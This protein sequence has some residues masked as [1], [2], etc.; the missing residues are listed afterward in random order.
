MGAAFQVFDLRFDVLRALKVMLPVLLEPL[1]FRERFVHE[2][3]LAGSLQSDDV[4][5]IFDAGVDE[6]MGPPFV[7]M[8]LLDGDELAKL[9]QRRRSLPHD[10]TV[11]TSPTPRSGSTRPTRRDLR[12]RSRRTRHEPANLIGGSRYLPGH[13]IKTRLTD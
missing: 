12:H 8:E 11:T 6:A 10:E 4:V 13:P 1:E 2:A 5:R 7:V 3:R 9:A